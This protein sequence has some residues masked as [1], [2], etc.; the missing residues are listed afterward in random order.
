M[1]AIQEALRHLQRGMGTLDVL[2]KFIL[3]Q[4][5]RIGGGKT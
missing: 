1:R 2:G 4:R 5:G 3:Q